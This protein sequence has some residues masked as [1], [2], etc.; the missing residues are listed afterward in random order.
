MDYL[1]F[2][3]P[4]NEPEFECS[5]CG[6]PMSEDKGVCSNVCFEADMR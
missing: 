5:V 2:L 4:A 3:D 6:R 1:N